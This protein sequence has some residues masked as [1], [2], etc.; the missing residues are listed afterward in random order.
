MSYSTLD[1]NQYRY[2][3][4]NGRYARD[5]ALFSG[6]PSGFSKQMHADLFVGEPTSLNHAQTSG[7]VFR[8][9]CTAGCS[10]FPALVCQGVISQE[11]LD[12]VQLALNA[13]RK[14]EANPRDPRTVSE[15]RSVFDHDPALPLPWPG[16]RN[17]GTRFARRFR[18]VARALRGAGT[19]YR[20]DGCTQLR[21]YPVGSIL[22]AHAIAIPPN[23][24]I[25]C[26]SF[27]GLP[28]FLRAGVVLHE[29]FH[30]RFDPCFGHGVCETKRT[31]A[32]CY[33]AFAL[34]V[35]GHSPE[36][37]VLVRCKALKK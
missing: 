36:Q 35:A 37:L 6:V 17:S 14:L 19:L 3:G 12:A 20:C 26:P 23:E 30:L 34:R 32:Y 31:S 22:D 9:Q 24:V 21:E 8:F 27:W 11:I 33:E 13:S 15:L 28:V 7:P 5:N 25:L 29:M 1:E 2:T 16:I 4:V 18:A 10:P